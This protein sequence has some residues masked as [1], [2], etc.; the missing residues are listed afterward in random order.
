MAVCR[1]WMSRT[2]V[3]IASCS[4]AALTTFGYRFHRQGTAAVHSEGQIA[5]ADNPGNHRISAVSM[6][7]LGPMVIKTP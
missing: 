2:A 6:V 3:T 1:P 5:S 7:E 4:R